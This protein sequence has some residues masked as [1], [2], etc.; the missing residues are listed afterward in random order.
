MWGMVTHK[1]VEI[2]TD[3]N[4][5]DVPGLLLKFMVFKTECT[6]SFFMRNFSIRVFITCSIISYF[7]N[8]VDTMQF[9]IFENRS[10]VMILLY[11]FGKARYSF[12]TSFRHIWILENNTYDVFKTQWMT[13]L[14]LKKQGFVNM[15]Y[16]TK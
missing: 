10:N 8:P 16:R 2:V 9:P 3:M 13:L 4:I 6:K 1:N 7:F 14:I 5:I 12:G 15:L 11:H